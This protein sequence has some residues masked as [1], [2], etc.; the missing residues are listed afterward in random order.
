MFALKHT[1]F[2]KFVQIVIFNQST[3]TLMKLI[4]MDKF[5]IENLYYGSN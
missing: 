2:L 4:H 1:C 5:D 3:L